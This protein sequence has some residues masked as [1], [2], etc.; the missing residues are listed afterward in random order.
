MS[1]PYPSLR[2]WLLPFIRSRIWT[3]R[4]RENLPS[5]GGYIL[6]PNHQAWADS[7]IVA[8]AVYRRLQKELRFVSMSGKYGGFGTLVIDPNNRQTVIDAAVQALEAGH[9]VVIFPEGNSNGNPE[10]RVGKTGVA[11]LAHRTGCPVIPVGVKGTRG[12]K[13][14]TSAA[15]FFSW[16]RPC[17]I[18]FGAPLQFEKRELT[19]HDDQLLEATTTTIMSCI[20]TLSGKPMPGQGPSL[21]R[22]GVAWY[23]VWR[24]V[25]PLFQWRVRI[26][27]Q[28]YL[29]ETGP[30]IL[31]ANHQSYFDAPALS[32][33]AFHISGVQPMYPT[34]QTVSDAFRRVG[35]GGLMAMLGMIPLDNTNKAQV[36]DR[37]IAHLRHGG[38]VGIFPEGMRNKPSVNPN[39]RTEMLVGKTG[40]VRL[41]LATGAPIIPVTISAPRGISILETILN[42]LAVWKFIR[43]QIG[44]P[45]VFS[46]RPSSP[47][48]REELRTLTTVLMQHIAEQSGMTY[49]HSV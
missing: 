25:R 32:M 30:Y 1:V 26:S 39:W 44:A 40:A 24:V 28:Q 41:M 46:S 14:W 38:V 47:P 20:S 7:P 11:R 6:A 49:P 33:A 45:I 19:G 27:G 43:I 18:T 10:L 37:A 22:R 35:G 31:A 8:A 16:W 36:L 3:I 48:T 12:V 13:P 15:W 34:K 2:W 23:F 5:S 4:G 21:E 42:T 29:P 17:H 9:P